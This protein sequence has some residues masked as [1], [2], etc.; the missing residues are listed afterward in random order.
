M[1]AYW[2]S[3]I[4]N[5]V[6]E[7][8]G[9]K[10]L[11]I[12]SLALWT[13]LSLIIKYCASNPTILNACLT[14]PLFVPTNWL[15]IHLLLSQFFLFK[16]QAMVRTQ[17]MGLGSTGP[18]IFHSSYCTL[19]FHC[20]SLFVHHHVSVTLKTKPSLNYSNSENDAFAQYSGN[21]IL[22][23]FTFHSFGSF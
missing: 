2:C 23:C 17:K 16:C 19:L 21:K 15:C 8:D 22:L 10:E 7:A 4:P 14:W 20:F 13:V 1:L 5:S 18:Y 12:H 6:W 11:I 3:H 9:W